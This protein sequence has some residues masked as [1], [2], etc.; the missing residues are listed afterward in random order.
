M[1]FVVKFYKEVTVEAVNAT[2][3]STKA[4]DILIE[5]L[6]DKRM[7]PNN[8]YLRNNKADSLVLSVEKINQ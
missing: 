3:A 2:E 4:A 7:V 5:S 6:E 8:V 1:K